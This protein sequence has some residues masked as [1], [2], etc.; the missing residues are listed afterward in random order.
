MIIIS[1]F[2][3]DIQNSNATSKFFDL[4]VHDYFRANRVHS[5]L[6]ANYS[7]TFDPIQKTTMA[8]NFS[9]VF[10]INPFSNLLQILLHKIK[11]NQLYQIL[12]YH[13]RGDKRGDFGHLR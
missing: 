9:L 11:K 3:R 12:P 4:I 2:H 8:Q 13:E 7:T 6:R 10:K 1:C 5:I